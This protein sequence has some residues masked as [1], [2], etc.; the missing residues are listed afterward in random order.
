VRV[1]PYGDRALLVELADGEEAMAL[2]ACLHEDPPDCLGDLVPAART[3]LVV[4]AEGA[5]V[6]A[7]RD[8]VTALSPA[9]A[10]AGTTPPGRWRS[11]S[12]TTA[13]TSRRW[14]G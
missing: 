9:V 5:T 8:A 12:S 11:R 4:A 10:G 2:A 7:L 1:L 14:P 13:R 6:A 3:V